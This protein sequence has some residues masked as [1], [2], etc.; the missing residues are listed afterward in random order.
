MSNI[1]KTFRLEYYT[2]KAIYKIFALVY[3]FAIL[4]AVLTKQPAITIM[5][6]VIFSAV[7]CSIVFS[8]HEKN[9]LSK[10]YG[11]L[12]LGTFDVVAGRYLYALCFGILNLVVSGSLAY[13]I[14]L[15]A[16][17]GM[18]RILFIF[19]L[20]AAFLYLCLFIGVSFPIY[21]KFG[22]SKANIFTNLQLYII[23]ISGV[24]ISKKTDAINN[25]NQFFAA[26]PNMIWV[27]GIGT[28]LIL[29][30][31]SCSLSCQINKKNER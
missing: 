10:L 8:I 15:I 7:F 19:I 29:L 6:V 3:V 28:G 13:I 21:Y 27:T 4:L 5:I 23:F 22:F 1:L 16:N 26:N 24:L 20:S 9:N 14:S 25:I 2:L 18:D 30:V 31:I 12:P 11:I 17:E